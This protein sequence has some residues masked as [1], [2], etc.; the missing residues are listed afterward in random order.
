MVSVAAKTRPA[1]PL[2]LQGRMLGHLER[3]SYLL[4]TAIADL[5]APS[6]KERWFLAGM[7]PVAPRTG[8]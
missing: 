7:R 5:V 1:P 8:E 2:E 3:R 4:M 6:E